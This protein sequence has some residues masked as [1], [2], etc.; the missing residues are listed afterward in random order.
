LARHRL[1]LPPVPGGHVL[2]ALGGIASPGVRPKL[3]DSGALP[4]PVARTLG[5]CLFLVAAQPSLADEFDRLEGEALAALS[6]SGDAKVHSSLTI[7]EL[8]QLPKVLSDARSAF[9][10]VKTGQGNVA[11]L[12]VSPALRQT[13]GAQGTP[14][15]VLLLERYDSFESGN[16]ATRLA[17]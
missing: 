15:A 11:R 1:Q 2:P 16:L 9:L 6:R 17:R 5:V 3:Q 7:G 14:I 10:V 4:M 12:L 13:P 8:D